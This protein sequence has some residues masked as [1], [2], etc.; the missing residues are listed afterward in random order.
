MLAVSRCTPALPPEGAGFAAF[1]AAGLAAAA[2]LAGFSAGATG[3][4]ACLSVLLRAIARMS[5]TLGRP[6]LAADF[7]AAGFA[8]GA[9]GCSSGGGGFRCHRF[10]DGRL[11]GRWFGEMPPTPPIGPAQAAKISATDIF[12]RSVI[13]LP[14]RDAPRLHENCVLSARNRT[15]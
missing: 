6:P 9:A 11:F 3:F 15:S 12:L 1:S 14:W 13:A 2:G 7:A 5:A 8:G 10:G 4:S